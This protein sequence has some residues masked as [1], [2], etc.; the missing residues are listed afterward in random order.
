MTYSNVQNEVF[1]LLLAAHDSD[2]LPAADEEAV[3]D[4]P[5]FRRGVDVDPVDE[6]LAVEEVDPPGSG[7]LG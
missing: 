7:F 1:K 5:G 3:L 6:V 2:R 4:A